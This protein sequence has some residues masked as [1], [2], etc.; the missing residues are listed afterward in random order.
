MEE[1][2]I[3]KQELP[4]YKCHK[5]VQAAKIRSVKHSISGGVSSPSTCEVI[6]EGVDHE[7]VVV[8]QEWCQK[9]KPADGG[10]F[11]RYEDGYESVSPT[12]AFE[13]GYTLIQ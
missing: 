9:H 2:Q 1:A 5:E 7:P 13:K 8:T 3:V 12:D 10:Y 6:L 11:V 4:R